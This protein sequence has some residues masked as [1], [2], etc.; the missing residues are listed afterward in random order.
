LTNDNNLIK[1]DKIMG[2]RIQNNIAA[3]NAHKNLTIADSGLSKSLERLS[4]GYRI[5]RAADDAAG[6]SISLAFRADIASFKVASRNATEATSLLQVAEGAMDQIGNMLTR[7]KEL[8]TQAASANAGANLDKLNAEAS[9]LILEIDRIADSTEYAN[10]KLIN[11]SYGVTV[12][13]KAA[14]MTGGAGFSSVS[15][16]KASEKYTVT[17]TVASGAGTMMVTTGEISETVY[18]TAPSGT[19]T[20]DVNIGSLGLTITVN[21]SIGDDF[22]GTITAGSSGSSTFQIGAENSADN[23]VSV[24]I[25][26]V[27]KE[28]SGLNISSLSLAS[29]ASAQAA[30]DTIDTAI[31]SLNSKRGDIGAYM[32]RLS[33]A[34]ANLAS[35][36]ENVTAAESVIRD[37]DMAAEMTTFTKNQILL[38]AGTAM[39]AQANMA[40]QAVLSLFG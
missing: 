18:F 37:V 3:L 17:T 31:S 19:N 21:A 27:T 24:S 4:S 22:D 28:S 16:M 36:I 34:S 7:L 15:G 40:P 8:A 38:Q 29:A 10:T 33:Y 12:N 14:A 9:K 26:D 23:R 20:Q 5:N 32:N 1:E 39:L 25:G 35:T 11:G 30:L 6:M 13:D 2:L